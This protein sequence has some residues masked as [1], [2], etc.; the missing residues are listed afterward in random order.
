[1]TACQSLQERL[2]LRE[3]SVNEGPHLDQYYVARHTSCPLFKLEHQIR[4]L[5]NEL[6]GVEI[7]DLFISLPN[8]TT[9]NKYAF[10]VLLHVCLVSLISVGG[11]AHQSRRG[12]G[13]YPDCLHVTELK[14]TTTRLN[15]HLC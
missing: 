1:M 14:E 4:T 2:E 9:L 6:L 11:L 7:K 8:M 12:P 13:S 15:S 5:K 3:W 10:S